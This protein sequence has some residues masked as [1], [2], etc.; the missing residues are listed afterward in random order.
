MSRAYF[1]ERL[2]LLR[3]NAGLSQKELADR[4][5]ISWQA[6]S[7]WE[8][9]EAIPRLDNVIRLADYFRV[10]LDFLAGRSTSPQNAPQST[11]SQKR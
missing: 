9:G 11:Q 4:T 7:R 10:S 3:V 6:I 2:K 1:A 8:A 5:L